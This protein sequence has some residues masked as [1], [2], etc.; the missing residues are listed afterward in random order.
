MARIPD[1]ELERLKREVDL[2]ELVRARGV[3]L[4]AG[5]KDLR[6][7]VPVSPGPDRE[8][9]GDP[10]RNLFHCLGCGARGSVVDWVMQAEGVS[11]RHA[12]EML[13]A[14]CPSLLDGSAGR[15]PP[16]DSTVREAAAPWC[17]PRGRGRRA[18]LP[19]GRLL[20]RDPARSARRPLEYLERARPRRPARRSTAS[21]SASPTAPS[22]TAC[23]RS[24]RKNGPRCA[25]GCRSSA[26]SA[27]RPR[28]PAAAA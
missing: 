20:P 3:E 23:R 6:R 19:G 7:P 25:A 14:D 1:D 9:V 26:S 12:V 5:G 8:P 11:F 10:A 16:S 2:V 13:R 17:R 15:P 24:N 27:H 18:A 21:G 4:R 22:A 28:A